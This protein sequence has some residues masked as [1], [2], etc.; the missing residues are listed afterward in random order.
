MCGKF[1]EIYKNAKKKFLDFFL[2]CNYFSFCFI[3]INVFL[4]KKIKYFLLYY[5]S[6]SD[7]NHA[8]S[9]STMSRNLSAYSNY[10]SLVKVCVF[11]HHMYSKDTNLNK[12]HVQRN[13]DATQKYYFEKCFVK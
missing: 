10:A 13:P 4:K 8:I 3:K 5:S 11:M 9:S 12:N 1:K 6:M 2:I 7:I